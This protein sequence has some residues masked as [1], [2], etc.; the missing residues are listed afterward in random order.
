[1]SVETY[2]TMEAPPMPYVL[3][4]GRAV[5]EPGDQHPARSGLAVFDLL[6]VEEGALY[7]GEEDRQW[8]IGPGHLLLLLPGR[9]HYP[10]K[11][12]VE[13]TVFYWVHFDTAGRYAEFRGGDVR[14]RDPRRGDE[15]GWHAWFAPR[16]LRLPKNGPLR[17]PEEAFRLLQ[18][19]SDASARGRFVSLWSDQQRF[20]E[21]V[22]LLEDGGCTGSGANVWKVAERIE[23]YVKLHYASD[24]TNQA[25]SEALHFHP[26][27]L[28]RCMKAA[29][30][31]TPLDFLHRYRIEQAKLL[32]VNTGL[33]V[34]DIAER[35]GFPNAPYFTNRFKREVGETPL[36]FRRRFHEREEMERS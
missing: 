15:P 11:P 9:Y 10:V 25:L 3:E 28:L 36:Q 6:V 34:A 29:F 14:F 1:M 30:G 20:I 24:I 21:L 16:T 26:N 27:Y 5:Y 32:L 22:Q 33:R 31:C 18:Q 35:V 7:V 19:L 23:A 8:E 13:R 4:C 12:C 2:L 17:F